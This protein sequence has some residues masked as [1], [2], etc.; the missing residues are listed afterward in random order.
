MVASASLNRIRDK[1]QNNPRSTNGSAKS[2]ESDLARTAPGL[3]RA[4]NLSSIPLSSTVDITQDEAEKRHAVDKQ[5]WG[6]SFFDIFKPKTAFNK[7]VNKILYQFQKS[8]RSDF[9]SEFR[10]VLQEGIPLEKHLVKTSDNHSVEL[11]FAKHQNTEA[12]TKIYFHGNASNIATLKKL[13]VEDYQKG[14]NVC[15]FSYRAYSGNHGYPSEAGLIDDTNS[16]INFL[17]SKQGL[18]T[19]DL[20]L[21]AHSLGCTVLLNTLAQR[22]TQNPQESFGNILLMSPFKSMGD[23]IKAKTKIIPKSLINLLT[24]TW[25]N[26]EAISKLKDKVKHIKIMHGKNDQVIPIQDSRDLYKQAQ[27]YSISSELI[28]LENIGHNDI[29]RGMKS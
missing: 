23:I 24:N 14:F 20:D 7:L 9:D 4:L 18:R 10:K 27:S 21:E 22:V 6:F 16:V 1:N 19:E 8:H 26:H 5:K 25:N 28:E 15:L 29:K 3:L 2:L 11:W 12:K 17:K 13:A